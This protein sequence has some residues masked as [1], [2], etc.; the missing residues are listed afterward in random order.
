MRRFIGS[1]LVA[2]VVAASLAAAPP[3][4]AQDE[5]AHLPMIFVHGGLGSG[6]QFESQA[7]RFASNGWPAEFIEMFEH[8]S[9]AYPAS[10]DEVWGRLDQAIADLLATTG[11]E[12]LHLLGH[13]QGT[14]VL[15]GYL[16]SSPE[17]AAN[18]AS[19]VNLDGGSGG[20]VPE[21]VPTLAV[22]GEGDPSREV[23]GATNVRFAEQGHTEVVNSPETF[24]EIYRF[25]TGNEPQFRHVVREPA[26]QIKVSGRVQLF[27]ENVGAANATLEIHQVEPTTGYR[28]S[29]GPAATFELSGNGD[30]GPFAADGN[31]TYEFAIVRDTGV[32]HV[33]VQQF[34]RSNRWVRILTSE[35]GGLAD[36]FW[37][38][39]DDHSNVVVFRNKEFWGGEG[40][41]SD[42]LM[43]NGQEVLNGATSPRSNR[44]I[45]IFLHDDGVNG[46]TNLEE[47]T[48][49]F[50]VSFLTGIDIHLPASSPPDATMAVVTTPRLGSGT[51]AICTPNWASSTDRIS[52]QLNAYHQLVNPDGTAAAGFPNPTCAAAATVTPE[53]PAPIAAPAPAPRPA[54][55]VQV[56]PRF[57]G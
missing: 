4:G 50:G 2:I 35:P 55:P 39:G 12:Q 3:S 31:A 18:V 29:A 21:S 38:H 24:V 51:E 7:L 57:T 49:P 8:N 43:L 28:V 45:G 48:A 30:W 15:Q 20:T 37:E 34:A 27:P 36:S 56:T 52:V 19:Y 42:S 46:Q 22:W 10:E 1:L 33:Y 26:D 25:F 40:A 14:R 53:A 23:P 5:D 32:H 17:R 16:S 9:L 11:A 54:T 41:A 13:S 6:Q 47:P 44:T